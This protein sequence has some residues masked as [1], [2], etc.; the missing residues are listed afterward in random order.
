MKA[1]VSYK[2]GSN[3]SVIFDLLK[4]HNIDF[5]DSKYDINI[6]HSFQG[7]ITQG[8]KDCDFFV[9]IY[10]KENANIAFEIG[11][12]HALK[13]P[14]FAVIST[15][16]SEY[17]DF[18]LES[19]HVMAKPEDYEKIK[20]N[21]DIFIKNIKPKRR[22]IKPPK[23]QT[24]LTYKENWFYKYNSINIKNEV[25]LEKFVG[26]ILYKNKIDI[27]TNK[28]DSNKNYITDYCIWSDYL[29]NSMGN[30]IFIEVKKDL[31]S[32]NI[33]SLFK[34]L[35]DG[36]NNSNAKSGI[37][38]YEN[39]INLSFEEL[40]KYNSK[41]LFFVKLQDFLIKLENEDFNNA[42]LDIRNEIVNKNK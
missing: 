11:I 35:C 37:V 20:F 36:I 30:P 42:I 2:Y 27:I 26:E 5:F 13:K 28:W 4:N 6:G 25:T 31:H 18:L 12:A 38:F 15:P 23:I 22:N 32:R 3:I 41:K 24:T 17:P 7:A 40:N 33:K 10:E 1:F 21:L 16:G 29:A 34:E 14:I 9:A 19:V 39:L 8:I